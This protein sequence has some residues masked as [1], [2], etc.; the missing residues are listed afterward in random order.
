MVVLSVQDHN[1]SDIITDVLE[2]KIQLLENT[3]LAFLATTSVGFGII[4]SK[5]V[6]IVR[7]ITVTFKSKS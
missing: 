3:H 1:N 6:A 7:H 5:Q 2:M 4:T